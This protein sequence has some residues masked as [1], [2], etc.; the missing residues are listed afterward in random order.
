MASAKEKEHFCPDE[1]G[2]LH[3][4]GPVRYYSGPGSEVPRLL[5]SVCK[6]QRVPL[7]ECQT[8]ICASLVQE[9][10]QRPPVQRREFPVSD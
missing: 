9:Q 6:T 7:C 5:S 3:W 8:G 10:L 4:L 1:G 2:C